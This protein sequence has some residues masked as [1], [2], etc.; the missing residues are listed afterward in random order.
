MFGIPFQEDRKHT[1][2][3]CDNESLVKN[4][5]KIESTLNKKHSSLAYHY[6]AR[7]CVAAKVCTVAWIRTGENIADAMTKC[8]S[9]TIRDYLFGNWT[10]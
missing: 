5:S 4:S 2:I 6:F 1:Y 9:K 10:Y 7:W 3:L 8:L